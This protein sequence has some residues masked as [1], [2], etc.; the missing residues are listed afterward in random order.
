MSEDAGLGLGSPD[1]VERNRKALRTRRDLLGSTATAVSWAALAAFTVLSLWSALLGQTTLLPTQVLERFA[2]WASLDPAPEHPG[3]QNAWLGDTVDAAAPGLVLHQESLRRG[4]FVSWDPYTVGGAA[5]ASVP[6]DS[7]L[8]P[9]MLPWYVLPASYAPGAVKLVEIAT[10][11]LGMSLL[12][13]RFRLPSAAWALSSLIY[14]SSGFMVAWTN[15]PH[16]KVGALIPFLFWAVDVAVVDRRPRGAVAIAVVVASMLLSG[17]PAVTGM[18]LYAAAAYALARA[19]TRSRKIRDLAR[20]GGVAAGGVLAGF[21]LAAFQMLPFARQ[22]SDVIDFSVRQQTGDRHLHILSLAT[23]LVPEIFGGPAG[24][25][26]SPKGNPIETFSYFG[27]G[28]FVLVLV[29]LALPRATRHGRFLGAFALVGLAVTGFLIFVGGPVLELLQ[30]LPVFSNNR[31][32]RGLSLFGFFAA[33]AT[34]V[35]FGSLLDP[36]A[37]HTRL[38]RAASETRTSTSGSVPWSIWA[39]WARPALAVL[40]AVGAIVLVAAAWAEVPVKHQPETA[41]ALWRACLFFLV[42]VGAVFLALFGRRH[43]ARPLAA[44][45]LSLVVLI[46]ALTTVD[47]WWPKGV[48]EYVFADT[49]THEFLANNLG[50]DR[51]AT[52]AQAML[53][54]T[55]SAYRLRSA[56][57]HS[58]NTREWRELLAAA[59]PDVATTAT[60]LTL[61]SMAPE[62]L[63]SPA[64]DRLAVRYVVAD[65]WALAPGTVDRL[66][67]SDRVV[68][69]R[70]GQV[71]TAA[72][73]TPF[74]GVILDL[75]DGVPAQPEGVAVEVRV[76]DSRGK[77]RASTTQAI[78]EG[79]P[80]NAQMWFPLPGEWSKGESVTIEVSTTAERGLA[81]KG[82]SASRLL[83]SLMRPLDDGLRVARGDGA[84]VIERLT[85]LPRVRWASS[86]TVATGADAVELLA[87]AKFDDHTVVLDSADDLLG[88]D[89]STAKVQILADDPAYQAVAV[90][91]AG[92]GWLVVADAFPP[93]GWQAYLDGR[94]V[95]LVRADHALGAVAVD[96]GDHLVELRYEPPMIR[97]GLALTALTALILAVMLWLDRSRMRRT[98]RRAEARVLDSPPSASAS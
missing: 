19:L 81:V 86:E 64:L 97:L 48:P 98:S 71:G 84:L 30:N 1:Q 89:G 5:G 10:I 96:A 22:A 6:D 66:S 12:L 27:V 46:P 14:A 47:V 32:N 68:H 33:V 57:G 63:A 95:D 56:T 43:V 59:D 75:P 2:P 65:P 16:T 77:V 24:V 82:A 78:P 37:P 28:T 88:A 42:S 49:P 36:P 41:A 67:V 60:Y 40:L 18:A 13:R 44:T 50:N 74:R 94:P 7:A 58:F 35:G 92:R 11:T 23:A 61:K 17:F 91:A 38:R 72:A 79:Y 51:F 20:S 53:P 9:I 26:W 25:Q 39:G 62:T 93:A 21:T 31:I 83:V 73:T 29:A 90:T 15:W 80:D 4:S 3:L 52:V 76:V 85:A 54:G 45:A 69:L 87:R 55:S 34:G 70:P 8:S